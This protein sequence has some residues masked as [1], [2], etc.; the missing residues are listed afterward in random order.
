MT[1]VPYCP[2][3]M[4]QKFWLISTAVHRWTYI[5]AHSPTLLS[6]FLRHS[7]FS[8]PSIASPTS[9]FILQT[10]LCFSYITGSSLTS[11]GEPPMVCLAVRTEK[12]IY[13]RIVFS[14]Q[15]KRLRWAVA[16]PCN[17]IWTRLHQVVVDLDIIPSATGSL[18]TSLLKRLEQQHSCGARGWQCLTPIPCCRAFTEHKGRSHNYL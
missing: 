2:R 16:L 10:F 13:Y 6:L 4:S 15:C 8:N 18:Y 12:S 17:W 9:Q 3:P 11:P 14:H 7:S 1:L 5:T